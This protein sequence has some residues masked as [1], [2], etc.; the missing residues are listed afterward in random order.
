MRLMAVLSQDS[1]DVAGTA[2]AVG[3]D[4]SELWRGFLSWAFPWQNRGCHATQASVVPFN[5]KML[6]VFLGCADVPES[7]I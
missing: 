6:S 5:A 4:M 7:Q 2:G 1:G 3:A